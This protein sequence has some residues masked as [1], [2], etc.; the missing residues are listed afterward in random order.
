M[1]SIT[2]NYRRLSQRLNRR[3]KL[4]L[5]YSALIIAGPALQADSPANT[6]LYH[7]S[8]IGPEVL[9]AQGNGC[10]VLLHGLLRSS[11]SMR[12][13]T[14]YLE[15]DGYMVINQDYPSRHHNVE[16]L[17]DTAIEEALGG[18]GETRPIHFVTHSLGGILVRSYLARHEVEDLGRVVM[19]A[20]PNQ[21][22]E[23]PD[24]L[25][26]IPGFTLLNGPAG[27]EL[28]THEES[29]LPLK[30]G[31]ANFDLGIIAGSRSINLVLSTLIPEADDGKVSIERTKLDGMSDH[32][33]LPVSH[34]FI[35]SDEDSIIQV[36]HYLEYGEFLRDA[37]L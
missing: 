10:T 3:V 29:S 15:A 11:S 8:S 4:G 18:C 32:I 12:K 14:D 36:L 27:K 1:F 5:I 2:R 37:Q 33:V 20:P 22:S 35:M 17:A 34:P 30:L 6:A 28:G 25:G 21:G 31:P 7:L 13:M 16:M 19:L 9:N 23:V 24:K 26:K